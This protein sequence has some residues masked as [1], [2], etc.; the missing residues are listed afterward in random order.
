MKV[1]HIK[2]MALGLAAAGLL[3][4]TMADAA[5]SIKTNNF[6]VD[7]STPSNDLQARPDSFYN[8]TMGYK[9]WTHHSSWMWMKLKKGNLYTITATAEVGASGFHPAVACWYRPQGKGLVSV[10]YAYAH[11]YNQFTSIIAPNQVDEADQKKLGTMKM[12]FEANGYDGDGME[13][14]LGYQY[15]QGNVVGVLD[16]VEGKVELSFVAKNTGV[17]QCAVGGINPDAG[18]VD[19]S[20]AYTVNTS[21]TGW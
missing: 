3:A 1:S 20:T 4:T 10:D 21:V 5:T 15:Q 8:L 9:G 11:F 12:Y 14:P 7:K 2:P 19:L 18:T 16:G 6:Y 13:Y 17:Y